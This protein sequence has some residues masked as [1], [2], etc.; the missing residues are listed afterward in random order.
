MSTLP[1]RQRRLRKPFGAL[2]K[3]RACSVIPAGALCRKALTQ[4]P[5]DG[6]HGVTGTSCRQVRG[7]GPVFFPGRPNH[8]PV[9]GA[10]AGFDAI[11]IVAAFYGEPRQID[12]AII[13]GAAGERT[14]KHWARGVFC[15]LDLQAEVKSEHTVRLPFSWDDI[16][17][18]VL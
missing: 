1:G 12:K 18:G 3:A 16:A 7:D 9:D 15:L 5:G 8:L 14:G 2:L 10:K 4:I 6:L 13:G 11:D 17:F